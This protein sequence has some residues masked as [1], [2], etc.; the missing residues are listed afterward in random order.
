MWSLNNDYFYYLGVCMCVCVHVC[1]HAY[2]RACVCAHAH[3]C[4]KSHFSISP[5]SLSETP[6]YHGA[7]ADLE[8][9]SSCLHRPVGG[10]TDMCNDILTYFSNGSFV[11]M[12]LI[13]FLETVSH[14][15]QVG[16]KTRILEEVP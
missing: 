3:M 11:L 9:G 2:V 7:Q 13:I 14:V 5:L 15:D 16:V 6:Y 8:L 10:I 1:M 4:K 12:D